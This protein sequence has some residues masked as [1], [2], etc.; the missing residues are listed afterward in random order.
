MLPPS[1]LALLITTTDRESSP[2]SQ[3]TQPPARNG[4]IGTTLLPAAR[5]GKPSAIQP[6]GRSAIIGK[7]L[8]DNGVLCPERDAARTD[9]VPARA[10]A[11]GG[12][13]ARHRH[14]GLPRGDFQR[15][16]RTAISSAWRCCSC[17]GSRAARSVLTAQ[18]KACSCGKPGAACGRS[19]TSSRT[20][21]SMAPYPLASA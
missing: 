5:G 7:V 3:V 6:L 2:F 10:T 14:G 1:A 19:P 8:P 12:R 16:R 4:A 18:F 13:R 9:L 17:P 15:R 21:A 11:L 20:P